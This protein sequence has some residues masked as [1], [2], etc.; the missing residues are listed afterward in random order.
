[1]LYKCVNLNQNRC[2]PHV[3][4]KRQVWSTPS[5]FTKLFHTDCMIIMIMITLQ[6]ERLTTY[7]HTYIIP[8]L[9]ILQ[10][11]SIDTRR[12]YFYFLCSASYSFIIFLI[13]LIANNR[14]RSYEKGRVYLDNS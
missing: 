4:K 13:R 10:R 14:G 7:I 8:V 6:P 12:M 2:K 11:W 9:V 5:Y 1:M 3:D